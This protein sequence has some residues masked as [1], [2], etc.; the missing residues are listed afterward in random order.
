MKKR[1]TSGE[2]AARW[3]ERVAVLLRRKSRDYG[4]SVANPVRVFAPHL[5]P[6]EAL[7]VRA[8]DKIARLLSGAKNEDTMVDLVGYIALLATFRDRETP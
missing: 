1:V 4:D 6:R 7:L 3:L 2:S 8:D 5:T